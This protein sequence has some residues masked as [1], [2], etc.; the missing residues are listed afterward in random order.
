MGELC[1]WRDSGKCRADGASVSPTIRVM[2]VVATGG[3]L[4]PGAIAL[5][6]GLM[7]YPNDVLAEQD[8]ASAVIR[9]EQ[10]ESSQLSRTLELFERDMREKVGRA[11]MSGLIL[12]EFA[13]MS[14]T[15]PKKPSLRQATHVASVI[16]CEQSNHGRKRATF[17]S[18]EDDLRKYFSSFRSV[19]HLWAAFMACGGDLGF[20]ARDQHAFAEFVWTSSHMLVELNLIPFRSDV[21]FWELPL[22]LAQ[23]IAGDVEFSLDEMTELIRESYRPIEERQNVG[24]N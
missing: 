17:P 8:F 13:A 16:A 5:I 12:V 19:A 9:W 7:H 23:G 2:P 11:K 4:V 20:L 21:F 3:E 10:S 15:G 18:D 6:W 1:D 24:G 14:R 22:S